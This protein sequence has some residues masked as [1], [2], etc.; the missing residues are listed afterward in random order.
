MRLPSAA[1]S[2]PITGSKLIPPFHPRSASAQ[3]WSANMQS[4]TVI[5][6]V[7]EPIAGASAPA[8]SWRET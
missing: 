5:A 4:V 8:L 7:I 1:T 2:T 6:A 3:R